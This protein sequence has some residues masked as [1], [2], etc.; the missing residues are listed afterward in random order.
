MNRPWSPAKLY[1]ILTPISRAERIEPMKTYRLLGVRLE[2]AGPF[3][4]ETIMGSQSAATTLYEVKSGDFIYS[5]L[6]ACRGAFGVISSDL[7]GCYVSG[8]FPT[9]IPVHDK[10][11]VN[12]LRLWFR[13]STTIREVDANCTG[14]TPLTR[15][16][17]K[18]NFFLNLEIQLPP[19][20]EQRRIVAKIQEL[21]AKIGEARGLR[22]QTIEDAWTLLESTRVNIFKKMSS[23]WKVQKLDEVAPINMGQSPPGESYNTF[24][25]GIPLL[26]GPTEFGEKYPT[27]V[28][29]TTAPTKLCKPGDI[30]LCVRGATT[31]RLNWADKEYC[32]GRGLAALTPNPKVCVPEYVYHFVETQTQEMLGL[33]AGS[34]FPNLPGA[35]LKVLEISIPPVPQQRRVVA[36]LDSL[37]AKVEGLKQLQKQTAAELDA[38]LPSILD[39][40]FKGEL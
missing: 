8:E 19:L 31:G 1:E 5:R 22:Q 33:A 40:A 38:L 2:G 3:H 7:D 39:K 6:F 17:F 12:F 24:G 29:W 34:T 35:K 15:N 4:R 27:P 21:A 11:D 26:N 36:Y 9:F 28:Q 23:S 30:L 32:I 16:R 14:S 25:D 37:E 10:V 20:G 18:E 13:L